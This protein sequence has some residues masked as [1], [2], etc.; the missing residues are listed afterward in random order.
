MKS[1]VIDTS[2]EFAGTLTKVKVFVNVIGIFVPT[3]SVEKM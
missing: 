2:I 1:A 3:L